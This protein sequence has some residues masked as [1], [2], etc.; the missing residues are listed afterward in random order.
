MLYGAFY[1]RNCCRTR[2]LMRPALRVHVKMYAKPF[3]KY[4]MKTA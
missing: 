3:A 4:E 1:G 2:T